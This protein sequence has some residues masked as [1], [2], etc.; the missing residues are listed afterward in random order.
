MLGTWTVTEDGYISSW[1]NGMT[2]KVTMSA[3]SIDPFK[4]W[5]S[6][7]LP[8]GVMSGWAQ[9]YPVIYATTNNGTIII[10]NQAFAEGAGW[11][12]PDYVT[13]IAPLKNG[14]IANNAGLGFDPLDIE[15]TEDGK[16]QVKVLGGLNAYSFVVYDVDPVTGVYYTHEAYCR[17]TIWTKD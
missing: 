14:T 9:N 6:G 5:I 3:D 4:I 16:L 17:N 12:E 15:E 2:Y 7:V 1:N 10:P 13:Y 11:W 8:Y